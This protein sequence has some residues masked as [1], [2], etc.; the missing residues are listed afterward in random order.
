MNVLL[1]KDR[2][3]HQSNFSLDA[4][5]VR[6]VRTANENPAD[7]TEF[8]PASGG[9]AEDYLNAIFHNPLDDYML[10][11][12]HMKLSIVDISGSEPTGDAAE[13]TAQSTQP[14]N[15]TESLRRDSAAPSRGGPRVTRE[16]LLM[17]SYKTVAWTGSATDA[18]VANDDQLPTLFGVKNFNFKT[19]NAPSME[20][21][22]TATVAE[23]TM[24]L[25]EPYTFS[26]DQVLS[27]IAADLGYEG[28]SSSRVIF[29]IDIWFSGW[30]EDGKH[31]DRIAIS[32]PFS[33][34]TS[35]GGGAEENV[36]T[37]FMNLIRVNAK[38]SQGNSE[39]T[40]NFVP[41]MYT[42]IM[43]AAEYLAIPGGTLRFEARKTLNAILT[44]LMSKMDRE[45][46]NWV[47]RTV[48]ERGE[49]DGNRI[50]I[51]KYEYSVECPHAIGS[52][53]VF[54]DRAPDVDSLQQMFHGQNIVYVI[55]MLIRSTETARRGIAPSS[56]P[57]VIWTVRV[58]ADYGE[59]QAEEFLS[60]Y[61]KI[62]IKFI[63]EPFYDFRYVPNTRAEARDAKGERL[64]AL[65]SSMAIR[66]VYWF[67]HFGLNTEVIRFDQDLNN[68]YFKNVV[69]L[70][71][72]AS[73]GSDAR[74]NQSNEEIQNQRPENQPRA[75]LDA[76]SGLDSTQSVR[77]ADALGVRV[78]R[79]SGV[80]ALRRGVNGPFGNTPTGSIN[81]ANGTTQ[82]GQE[83]AALYEN[84]FNNLVQTDLIQLDNMEVRGDPRWL[85]GLTTRR[86]TDSSEEE[87]LPVGE[88]RSDC[89]MVKVM[90]PKASAYMQSTNLSSPMNSD[91]NRAYDLTGFYQINAVEHTFDSGMYTQKFTGSRIIIDPVDP[92]MAAEE[93][94]QDDATNE[95][96]RRES[97]ERPPVTNDDYIPW[98]GGA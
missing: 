45:V 88:L 12:Y 36:F 25:M 30:A 2:S 56:Y 55:N 14:A 11:R 23:A 92:A 80:G 90:T 72:N 26:F 41:V 94:A 6:Q 75:A 95:R 74:S 20:N 5:T 7:P 59:S 18:T 63:I 86:W 69:D 1:D 28:V 9:R 19:Y 78:A 73:F 32:N 98:A 39:L 61:K 81:G 96:L 38:V 50:E 31:Y 84:E 37:L 47:V 40:L 17:R 97:E 54:P 60:D 10:P 58:V 70:D 67:D 21:P 71:F 76:E 87:A 62:K 24:T 77:V 49:P 27:D 48:N 15:R 64:A 83:Q 66:R 52:D 33:S 44:T 42:P 68:F 53:I 51:Q 89:I 65:I 93:Q 35:S 4:E 79:R 34:H 91:E 46:G 82:T 85:F 16:Q 29:R 22:S 8:V 43:A 13:Q 57:R 3:P